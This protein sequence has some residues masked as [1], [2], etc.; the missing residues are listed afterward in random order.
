M[1]YLLRALLLGIAAGLAMD[2]M[3]DARLDVQLGPVKGSANAST[4]ALSLVN[5]GDQV[6]LVSLAS[7]PSVNARGML[8]NDA[9]VVKKENAGSIE[10]IGIM[11]DEIPVDRGSVPIS[12]GGALVVEVELD[13]SYRVSPGT[14]YNVAL[15]TPIAYANAD[16]SGVSD[17]LLERRG[18]KWNEVK[19]PPLRINVP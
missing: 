11:L 3:A 16:D 17:G 2:A 15:R 9:F 8:L 18:V 19:P 1:N 14:S 12:A 6:A 4:V 13:K 5:V 7:L 10:Y